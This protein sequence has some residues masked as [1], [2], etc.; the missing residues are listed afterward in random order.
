[1]FDV[2]ARLGCLVSGG[3]EAGRLLASRSSDHYD[4]LQEGGGLSDAGGLHGIIEH[5][6]GGE[7]V[8][9]KVESNDAMVVKLR[10]THFLVLRG[11]H[12]PR[13]AQHL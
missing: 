11:R 4:L 1:M 9:L 3:G 8:L 2:G 6:R 12:L 7:G 10:V 5:G 13:S